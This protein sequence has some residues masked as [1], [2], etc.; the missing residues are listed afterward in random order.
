MQCFNCI[1]NLYFHTATTGTWRGGLGTGCRSIPADATARRSFRGCN[2]FDRCQPRLPVAL[3]SHILGLCACLLK[4]GL[5]F[6]QFLRPLHVLPG[7]RVACFRMT[8]FFSRLALSTTGPHRRGRRSVLSNL[9]PLHVSFKVGTLFA[10]ALSCF[11]FLPGFRNKV[12]RHA[13]FLTVLRDAC[14]PSAEPADE[15]FAPAALPPSLK[16]GAS[17]CTSSPS[18]AFTMR[19]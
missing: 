9:A 8:R 5:L 16:V 15:A 17:S 12:V 4:V 3:F 2:R 18:F 10:C 7:F 1:N 19:F 14:R 6:A 13:P 11:V